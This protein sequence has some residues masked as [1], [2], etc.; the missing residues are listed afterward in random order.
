MNIVVRW[1]GICALALGG[2]VS[3]SRVIAA[4][5]TP[6]KPNP[7]PPAEGEQ[8]EALEQARYEKITEFLLAEYARIGQSNDWLTRSLV[9]ISVSRLPQS[10][11]NKVLLKI[12]KEDS[13]PAVQLVAWQCLLARAQT[14][15][16][17][18]FEIWW[19]STPALVNKGAFNGRLRADLLKVLAMYPPD[20]TTK[21]IFVRIFEETNS[22]RSIDIPVIEELGRTLAAWKS[23]DLAEGL[24]LKFKTL[25][26][27]YRAELVLKVAGSP[28][29]WIGNRCD[30]GLDPMWNEAK[31][32]YAAW[33][34]AEKD[35][36]KEKTAK[37]EGAPWRELKS[38][39][40]S[41]SLFDREAVKANNPEIRRDLELGTP[42]LKNFDVAFVVDATES[43][44]PPLEWLRNDLRKMMTILAMLSSRP[45]MSLTFYRDPGYQFVATTVPLT[46]NVDVLL[47]NLG[48][49]KAIGG[50]DVP[51]AVK[52]GLA[53]S[54]KKAGWDVKS[55]A[56]EETQL[57]KAGTAQDSKPAEAEKR[58][59][60]TDATQR[61]DEKDGGGDK[62]TPQPTTATRPA[63]L[64][65]ADL[66]V[67]KKVVVLMGDAPPHKG[68]EDDCIEMARKAAA[69]GFRVYAAKFATPLVEEGGNLPSFD[70]IAAA[71]NGASFLVE[72]GHAGSEFRGTKPAKDGNI[73]HVQTAKS[74]DKQGPSRELL[75][76]I[77]RDAVN[78]KYRDRMEMVVPILLE[79]CEQNSAESRQG[80]G[81]APTPPPPETGPAK[82]KPKPKQK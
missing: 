71:G 4:E 50:G 53:D 18:Q 42:G 11:A 34:K 1:A 59:A 65:P 38:S 55:T 12:L 62:E 52:E 51:E 74:T 7:T 76:R 22:L 72:F 21:K 67:D 81:P 79:M 36:W 82:A 2:I 30:L 13:S 43:M 47:K 27:A 3:D 16:P 40:L 78:P 9:A 5:E 29:P 14:I 32:E 63:P 70:A 58:P 19:S 48:Q 61:A 33:W 45:R 69:V 66:S 24:M 20:A 8:S 31:R 37:P 49:V 56:A 25:N 80:F 15:N 28:V 54:F 35:N 64:T 46:K 17:E 44:G 73:R 68:T 75:G 26:D 60:A 10:R 6:S 77:L 57:A 41:I 39:F 23:P